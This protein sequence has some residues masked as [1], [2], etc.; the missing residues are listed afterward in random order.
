MTWFF[1]KPEK[2]VGKAIKDTKPEYHGD[3][4]VVRDIRHCENGNVYAVVEWGQQS[5]HGEGQYRNY[6][7]DTI[8]E[9]FQVLN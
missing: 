3:V 7:P 8:G 5:V 6:S 4:G 2:Y 1:N 9:R